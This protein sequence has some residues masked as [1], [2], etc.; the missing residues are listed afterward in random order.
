MKKVLGLV[1]LSSLAFTLPGEA[2]SICGC[3]G[4]N[5]YMGL[6]PDFQ[7]H[8]IGFRYQFAGYHSQLLNDPTQFSTNYYNQLEIWGG[9]HIGKM[10]Q[11]LA[12]VPYYENRQI[13]DDGK[14]RSSGL[15]D[16]S[17]IGQYEVFH[18]YSPLNKKLLAEQL[19]WLGGGI[20][21]P[22]GA[23]GLSNLDS[24]TTVADINAQLGTG[25]TD[26]LLNGM[27]ILKIGKWAANIS[28]T[29]KINTVNKE[30]YR[31]G[32]KFSTVLIAQYR[33]PLGKGAI[34]PNMGIGY[35]HV[36]SNTMEGKEVEYT[37]SSVMTGVAGVE[38]SIRRIGIGVNG[39]LP[40]VQNFAGGQTRMLARAMFHVTYSF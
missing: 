14:M 4:G 34:A 12:F 13:D 17:A 18:I 29:Y 22:T 39:Q 3:G 1:F 2:C 38:Y 24:N 5:L 40:L 15:G 21:L 36:K 16:I 32:N 27:Y 8:F 10:I 11:V 20:K 30:S 31:Y 25:S 33:I 37:G 7:K 19:L 26:F 6:L 35:D 9:M 23:F 28:A